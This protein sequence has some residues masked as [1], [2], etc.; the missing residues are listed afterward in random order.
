MSGD[1]LLSNGRYRVLITAAGAGCSALDDTL[2]TRWSCDPTR[3]AEGWFLYLKDLDTGHFWSA[4][5]QPVQR[6]ADSY[7]V[8]AWPDSV[9]IAREDDGLGLITMIAVDPASNVEWRRYILSNRSGVRRRI[10]LT[11]CIEVV[12]DDP[13]AAA[14]H[15]A[16]SKLFVQTEYLPKAHALLARRRPR[17]PDQPGLCLGHALLGSGPLE[18][19]TDRARFIGRGATLGQPQALG[20][21]DAL[22]GTTGNVLDPVLSLRRVVSLDPGTSIRIDGILAA[23]RDRD[24]VERLL[25]AAESGAPS[26]LFAG[27]DQ[28]GELLPIAA[29]RPRRFVPA[30]GHPAAAASGEPLMFFNGLGGFAGD[31]SEYVMRLDRHDQGVRL[32]PLPW[33]NVIANARGGFVASETGLGFSWSENSRENR[34]TPWFNDPVC[35]PA[36]EALY[37]RDEDAGR[38]WSPTPGPV[39]G[40]GA[41]EVRHGFGYTVWR[42]ASAELDQEV[43]ALMPLT[44]PVKIIRLRM[45]NRSAAPRNLSVFYYAEWV[46]GGSRA[47]TADFVVTES[48][49]DRTGLLARNPGSEDFGNRVAF[50]AGWGPDER[51]RHFTSDRQSFLGRYGSTASPEAVSA[52]DALDGRVGSGRD[53]CAAL[54]YRTRLEPGAT[55]EWTFLLGQS[56]DVAQ[57]GALWTRFRAPNSAQ[58]CLEEVRGFWRGL[59]SGIQVSTPSPA[60]DLMVNG[61]LPYQNL[62]C[63]MWARSAFYQSGGA[64]GY[65]DQLQDAAALV[66]Q[67][68][69]L[70][71]Q[72]ILLHAGRQFVEGDVLHWWH[73]P[74]GRGIRTRFADDL[75]WLPFVTEGYLT[76]TGDRTILAEPA[77]F[78][79]GP[80]L[81]GGE[82]ERFMEPD[83]AGVVG[84]LYEHCCRAIDRSLAV[85]RHGL[86]LM[87]SGDWNDGMNRVGRLGRGES[88]W[89]GFFLFAILRKFLPLCRA[90][91]DHARIIRYERALAALGVAL[92]QAGWDG[93]WYR[94]AYYDDGTPLGSSQ[95][96]E[97]RIDAIAQAWSV[98]SGAAPPDRAALALDAMER[99]LVDDSA[100]LIRLLTPPFDRTPH[101]PGYIKGYVPGVR[102][103]GGQ[104]THAAL[105]AV[106]A[107]AEAGRSERAAALLALLNPVCHGDAGP[108]VNVYQGEPYVVAADV[109]GVEPHLGR[110][111]WTWYTGSAGWMYRVALESILGMTL[112]EGKTL[113]LCP[114]IPAEWPGFSLD[115]RLP[116]SGARYRIVVRR[117]R[118]ATSA[119]AN[120]LAIR[121]E[122]GAVLVELGSDGA[123]HRVEIELGPDAGPRYRPA[124]S[125]SP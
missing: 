45:T 73:P 81:T 41:Y 93:E 61:W 115:Y 18:W 108:G 88:V 78:L 25:A 40:A 125:T 4:G 76:T 51:G 36:G 64:F 29:P 54:Q 7:Q 87:G 109:Y 120:G 24:A 23:G 105:W 44:E 2:L 113:V 31:G 79:R 27:H 39:P 123:D 106:R 9:C 97:C 15:P 63:R 67:R 17:S 98:L 71:R 33:C 124:E 58:S 82:D 110:A 10:Q 43:L 1:R 16:F 8:Q 47:L 92:N 103:N 102:E 46:L 57:A 12:L 101:D 35:D 59:L 52:V 13:A 118:S 20:A 80:L 53:P 69:D 42:H 38:F 14:G 34:L 74:A 94:R 5:H 66:Y 122:Q 70:T 85:G 6:Q 19:E 95:S 50:A 55:A 32:P 11:T 114:C 37:V 21:E 90:R 56:E 83:D 62:S 84:D 26:A 22:S 48:S 89:L 96:D 107:L 72:Q 75:L 91:Q 117:T 30:A 3:E 104:Y 86:P 49:A 121:V 68:P 77:G 116:G 99:F 60:L 111:G 100:R 119:R 112:R 65:R 28:P